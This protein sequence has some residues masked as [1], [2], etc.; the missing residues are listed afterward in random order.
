MPSLLDSQLTTHSLIAL[1]IVAAS[2]LL[3]RAV[4]AVLNLIGSLLVSHGAGSLAVALAAQD[5]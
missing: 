4:R 2:F 5:R 1:A 3:G